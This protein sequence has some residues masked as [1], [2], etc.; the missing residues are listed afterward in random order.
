MRGRISILLPVRYGAFLC[1]I[2]SDHD[3]SNHLAQVVDLVL[4]GM[5]LSIPATMTPG[6]DSAMI[7][8]LQG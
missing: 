7:E 3:R 2:A 5:Q 4:S 6:T 8:T 1:F